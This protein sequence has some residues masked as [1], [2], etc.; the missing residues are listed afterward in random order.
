MRLL[1][2]ERIDPRQ[3]IGGNSRIDSRARMR[4]SSPEVGGKRLCRVELD[5]EE[6]FGPVQFG[7]RLKRETL[8]LRRRD[9][10]LDLEVLPLAGPREIVHPVLPARRAAEIKEL[11]PLHLPRARLREPV[12]AAIDR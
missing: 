1:A 5:R 8:V 10:A 4:N 3:L 6:R 9:A 2:Q 12:T 11:A 7:V